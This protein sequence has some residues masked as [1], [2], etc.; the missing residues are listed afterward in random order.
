MTELEMNEID[1]AMENG[2]CV[3][4]CPECGFAENV[5]PD[6]SFPCPECGEGKV[7]SPLRKHWLI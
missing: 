3:G 7:E 6:A 2:V 5:E 4:T 1:A